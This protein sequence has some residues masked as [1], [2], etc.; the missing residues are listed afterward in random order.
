MGNLPEGSTLD[1]IITV[2]EWGA[3]RN[4]EPRTARRHARIAPG[5]IFSRTQSG[6]KRVNGIYVREYLEKAVYHGSTK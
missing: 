6:K 3:W 5:A 1:S 4:L 2:A